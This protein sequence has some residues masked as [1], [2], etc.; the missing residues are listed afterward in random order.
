MGHGQTW[1]KDQSTINPEATLEEL[2]DLIKVVFRPDDD[3]S[4]LL[5]RELTNGR[6]MHDIEVK[7]SRGSG[8]SIN[9]AF[10]RISQPIQHGVIVGLIDMGLVKEEDGTRSP[11][12]RVRKEGLHGGVDDRFI[13]TRTK[14]FSSHSNPNP[15]PESLPHVL[16]NLT[17][18]DSSRNND[19][20]P[21]PDGV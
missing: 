13:A 20:D 10:L 19:D 12:R 15:M 9:D 16:P 5:V 4:D 8:R 11:Q 14:T 21:P 3:V 7:E 17:N 6:D 1:D 2:G 18:E